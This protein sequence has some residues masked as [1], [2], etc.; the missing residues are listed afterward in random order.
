MS[1]ATPAKINEDEDS[2]APF[3]DVLRRS[4]TQLQSVLPEHVSADRVIRV[5]TT[6]FRMDAKLRGCT[7]DSIMSAVMKACELG[8]EPGGA[9]REC[10]LVPFSNK[11]KGRDGRDTWVDEATLIVGYPGFLKLARQ[12]GEFADIGCRAVYQKDVFALRFSPELEMVH[13]PCLDGD[14][15]PERIVYAYAVLKSG[16]RPFE[17]MTRAQ[18]EAIRQR[19]KQ[20]NSPA[21]VNFWGEQARKVVLKRML[22]RQPLSAE[23]GKAIEIDN[24]ADGITERSVVAT[25]RVELQPG[26]TRAEAL[27]DRLAPPRAID[28]PAVP[29]GE[30]SDPDDAGDADAPDVPTER[31]PGEEG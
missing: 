6:A 11:K 25:S 15:G 1:T 23:L 27:A 28:G 8:L 20:P 16:E 2:N 29:S 13:E 17:Y 24:E 10:Y 5:A 31:E 18:V 9:K 26:Q 22:K 19:L 14:A 12:S 21:W 7:V 3:L 4:R 30:F